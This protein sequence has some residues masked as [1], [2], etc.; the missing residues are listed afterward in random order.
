MQGALGDGDLM[1]ICIAP[2]HEGKF[3]FNVKVGLSLTLFACLSYFLPHKA[4][5]Y[6]FFSYSLIQTQYVCVVTLPLLHHL[7]SQLLLGWG[8]S[9]DASSH[10]PR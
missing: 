4:A 6:V 2:D 7:I 1:L 10:I 8:G 5:F 9:E 3:G